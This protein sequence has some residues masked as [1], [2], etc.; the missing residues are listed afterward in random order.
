MIKP[1]IS[2][3][4]KG[5]GVPEMKVPSVFRFPKFDGCRLRF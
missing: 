1:V 3:T 5:T 4:G 2:G